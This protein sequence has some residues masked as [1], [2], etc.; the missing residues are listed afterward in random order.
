MKRI[1][2]AVALCAAALALAQQTS[3]DG[4]EVRHLAQARTE[5]PAPLVEGTVRKV[6]SDAKKITL[7][8][9]PIPNLEMPAMSMVFQVRDPAMLERVKAGDKVR[10]SA[11][12]INGGY[13][14]THIESAR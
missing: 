2:F 3:G 5:A 4:H 11:D 12:R 1:I 9:G 6:D 14:V 8:H 7:R 13:T 10:F